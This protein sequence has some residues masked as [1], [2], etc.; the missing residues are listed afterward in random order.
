[1]AGVNDEGNNYKLQTIDALKWADKADPRTWGRTTTL[2][3]A[4]I[5][6]TLHLADMVEGVAMNLDYICTELRRQREN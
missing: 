6:A 4:Q 2:A 3:K 5:L 1:M